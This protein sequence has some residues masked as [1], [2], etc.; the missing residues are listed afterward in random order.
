VIKYTHA[1]CDEGDTLV[2]ETAAKEKKSLSVICSRAFSMIVTLGS[3]HNLGDFQALRSRVTSTFNEVDQMALGAGY[4]AED[5]RLARYALT[6]FIDETI[7]RTD[8]ANKSQWSQNPLSLADFDDNR[9]GDEFFNKLAEIRKQGDS[10]ADLLEVFY[11]CLA[12]GFEGKYA[13]A[14]PMERR[15]LAEQIGRDLERIHPGATAL[16]PDWR[17]PEQL[18]QLV[19]GQLPLGVIA[20]VAA[21]IVFIVFIVLNVL[22]TGQAN[23]LAQTIQSIK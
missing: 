4:P 1:V 8:W 10:K 20:A 21:G 14:D 18:A 5:V 15:R 6:A 9:A 2:E 13:L 17:P 11:Y 23:D 3:G 12:L 22:L 16:S 19:G 7:A